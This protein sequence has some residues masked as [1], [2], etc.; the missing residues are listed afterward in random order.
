MERTMTKYHFTKSDP[1]CKWRN[2]SIETVIKLVGQLPKKEMTSFKFREYID[3]TIGHDFFRTP[4]QL[5]CQLGLYYEDSNLDIFI[6]R[7]TKDINKDEAELYMKMWIQR[8]YVPNP[9]TK[10]GFIGIIPSIN[11]LN[12][13]VEYL[14]DHPTKPN[15]AT[16]GAALFGGEMGNIG[17][18][19]FLLNEYSQII[20]VDKENNMTLLLN[21]R[22]KV[23]EKN[24][25]D[26][27]K[28]FFD[29]FK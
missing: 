25:R 7:F 28:A 2:A 21:R 14:N 16:A 3:K 26:D 18:V 5:A 6:P 19:K 29:H 13:L 4:Y 11:L 1:I 9:Y 12:S 15:L 27:K 22:G 24:D 23:E 8:Y 17:N 20:E 10:K